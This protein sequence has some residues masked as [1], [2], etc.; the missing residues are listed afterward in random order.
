MTIPQLMGQ[1]KTSEKWQL[2]LKPDEI[3]D[4]F[5]NADDPMKMKIA[6]QY[7]L[8]MF[9]GFK[10]DNYN[11][12]AGGL[13]RSA[14]FQFFEDVSQS[15][16]ARK[17]LRC[18]IEFH[19]RVHDLFHSTGTLMEWDLIDETINEVCIDEAGWIK[20]IGANKA[21]AKKAYEVFF[22]A[23]KAGGTIK[24]NSWVYYYL[25][26]WLEAAI[27][28]KDGDEFSTIESFNCLLK[29][30]NESVKHKNNL[31]VFKKEL[32]SAANK[33][34]KCEFLRR[35]DRAV[36]ESFPS[37]FKSRYRSA[38]GKID[39][40]VNSWGKNLEPDQLVSKSIEV[41]NPLLGDIFKD[42]DLKDL[43]RDSANSYSGVFR[44]IMELTFDGGLI[45][46]RVRSFSPSSPPI[47]KD[48][49]YK[50]DVKNSGK[51]LTSFK[52]FPRNKKPIFYIAL[53][54]FSFI[55][56]F[57]AGVISMANDCLF[58][59]F[60]LMLGGVFGKYGSL[61]H[62][63][64]NLLTPAV[65]TPLGKIT[66]FVSIMSCLVLSLYSCFL[67]DLYTCALSGMFAFGFN[68]MCSMMEVADEAGKKWNKFVESFSWKS[69]VG[70]LKSK[71]PSW[72][73]SSRIEV[74]S[75]NMVQS[76]TQGVQGVLGAPARSRQLVNN[77]K[78]RVDTRFGNSFR[79]PALNPYVGTEVPPLSLN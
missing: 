2:I 52:V 51:N 32:D 41:P 78:L 37:K 26:R 5:N 58:V 35:A 59:G 66:L 60:I 22:Q 64:L 73:V 7:V 10:T 75:K 68:Y 6:I 63:I 40:R 14:L 15:S 8:V 56:L 34:V 19:V 13:F 11:Q 67:G 28:D 21:L 69:V 25:C 76:V 70:W 9:R 42:G 43:F 65:N 79:S 57:T 39:E 29:N 17:Q 71:L 38:L 49:V 1:A 24:S 44:L 47:I 31:K 30:I 62:S 55:A 72:M 36:F 23:G 77:I 45:G 4:A 48:G 12:E 53:E 50:P 3:V 46:R 54:W 20:K 16:R 18:M 74:K 27:I 61:S 33:V